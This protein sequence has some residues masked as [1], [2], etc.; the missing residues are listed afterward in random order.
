[1]KALVSGQAG[2]AIIKANDS[3]RVLSVEA[4][5]SFVDIPTGDVRLL[6]GN[7]S[8]L[9]ELDADSVDDLAEAIRSRQS[10]DRAL[11][12][13]LILLDREEH[14]EI[15]SEAAECLRG[16]FS[17]V[18]VG[19]YVANRLY[20]APMPDTGDIERAIELCNRDVVTSTFFRTL[21]E[22]Q[23][24]IRERWRA[25]EDLPIR[26]FGSS[27]EKLLFRSVAIDEGAFRLFVT[28]REKGD[29]ALFEM[30]S[31]PKFRGN[32]KARKVFQAWYS[33]FKISHTPDRSIFVD[34]GAFTP[35]ESRAQ[36]PIPPHE[37]FKRAEKQRN[38]I[39]TLL[40]EGRVDQALDYTNDLILDQRGSGK[41]EHLA[42]SL[43]DLAQSAKEGGSP[44][45]QLTFAKKATDEAPQDAWAYATLGDAYRGV[46]QYT[47]ALKAFQHAVAFGDQRAGFLGRAEV[48]KDLGQLAEALD[49]LEFCMRTF[50]EDPV[51]ANSR[52]A[53]LA[54]FGRLDE[55]LASYDKLLKHYAYDS[56][57]RTGQAQV[58]RELGRHTEALHKLD[59]I[60]LEFPTDFFS[61][62]TRSEVI[63]EM[64]DLEGAETEAHSLLDRFPD[65]VIARCTWAR[66]LRDLGRFDEALSAYDDAIH[67]HPLDISGH[68]GKADTYR[69][70]GRLKDARQLYEL[71]VER[72][73]RIGYARTGLASVLVAQSEYEGAL[74]LLPET[75]PATRSEWVAFHI[76]G[77]SFL[78][79]SN[80]EKALEILE[81]GSKKCPWIAQRD[82]FTTALASYRIREGRYLESI[83]LVNQV[84]NMTLSSA[85]R[86]LL[87]HAFGELNDDQEFK[88]AHA[89][90]PETASPVDLNLRDVLVSHYQGI[91]QAPVS[92]EKIFAAECDLLLLAA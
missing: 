14:Q 44:D 61:A 28:E 87:M 6:L 80:F 57:P 2:L 43:C 35:S 22:D 10:S 75:L 47:D 66:I 26:L 36:R 59:A 74:A 72:S 73:G 1:M 71:V 91:I 68:I 29:W 90:I 32:P 16:L 40:L 85:S 88:R 12:F 21:L 9:T 20:S 65:Q 38:A 79:R 34:E 23:E 77:M 24:E 25:W 15:R 5:E 58:L 52:A 48:L 18:S 56:I 17:A 11:Q 69:K 45:L 31:H 30:L 70:L 84:S 53:A 46:G 3:F 42:K 60:V 37:A 55:A 41:P 39:K 51:A 67:F 76:R 27:Q 82:Y 8:D 33:P 62:F 63:R 49:V 64:G 89:A 54:N 78:R 86:T 81:W 50:P 7:L 4:S 13:S 19:T 92:A 83:D